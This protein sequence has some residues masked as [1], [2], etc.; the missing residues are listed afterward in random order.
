MKTGMFAPTQFDD[1]V[2]TINEELINRL[3]RIE[4]NFNGSV[5]LN[6]YMNVVIR[7]ICIRIHEKSRTEIKTEPLTDELIPH[8]HG[9]IHSL[10][11]QDEYRRLAIVLKLY[12]AKQ[13]KL[14]FCFKIYF[15]MPVTGLD[16]DSTFDTATGVER[17]YLLQHF[18]N[19]FDDTLEIDNFNILAPMMNKQE[20]NNTTGSSL[21]RWTL[22]HLSRVIKLL[23]GTPPV[24]THTKETVKILFEQF[25]R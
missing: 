13:S 7:N 10:M 8:D 12:G 15:R 22:E 5:L 24:K 9:N 21:R 23:N 4:Q 18:G 17:E 1:T 14:K 16:V 19:T 3:H 2:Q 25:S 6:T 11:F 20:R